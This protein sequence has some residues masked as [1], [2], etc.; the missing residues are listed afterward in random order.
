MPAKT[1]IKPARIQVS[2]HPETKAVIE[3][4]AEVMDTSFAKIA[5]SILD[6][7]RAELAAVADAMEKAK[8]DPENSFSTLSLAMVEAQR[9]ILDAQ[10]DFIRETTKKKPKSDD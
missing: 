1:K 7:N 6:D 10:S 3:R 8:A 9:H 5:G 2:I 4:L